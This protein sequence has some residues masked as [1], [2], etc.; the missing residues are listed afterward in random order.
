MLDQSSGRSLH[1]A[2][3]V[4]HMW[5]RFPRP[6]CEE[7]GVLAGHLSVEVE[8]F[9]EQRLR[10]PMSTNAAGTP[11][12]KQSPGARPCVLGF[13][14]RTTHPLNRLL[15]CHLAGCYA[16]RFFPTPLRIL[17]RLIATQP[18]HNRFR[19]RGRR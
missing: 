12:L 9:G 17:A 16:E 6:L 15:F 1:F 7:R 2:S 10:E 8:L 11:H 4:W 5:P 18:P 19:K 14:N 3:P 13:P